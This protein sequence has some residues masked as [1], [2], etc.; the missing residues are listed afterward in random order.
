MFNRSTVK[1]LSDLGLNNLEAN[2]Y[3]ALLKNPGT[4]GYRIAKELG[5][6]VSNVYQALESLA[7]QG[8]ALQRYEGKDR[9]YSPLP[10]NEVI[11]LFKTNHENRI[12]VLEDELKDFESPVIE[13][14]IY[15]INSSNQLFNKITS[16]LK[17]VNSSV[18]ITADSFFLERLRPQLETA[19]SRGK[20]ILILGYEDLVFKNCDFLKLSSGKKAP[21]P[22]HWIIIDIDGIQHLIAFF[23]KPDTLTHAVWCNDQYVSY[24]IHF[25]MLADFTLMTFFEEAHDKDEYRDIF[26]R[27]SGLY[28]KYSHHGLNL[29]RYY[30]NSTLMKNCPDCTEDE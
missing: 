4:T 14:A 5:K 16:L 23:E 21:W 11:S 13:S 3:L 9:I 22:G 18:L 20:T 2:V 25:F 15:K 28:N 30:S 12:A 17:E 29:T 6:A 19:G 1:A 24:W 26:K 27:I 10:L 8:V 7:L